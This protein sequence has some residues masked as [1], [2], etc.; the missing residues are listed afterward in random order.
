MALRSGISRLV[1][2][3]AGLMVVSVL[4]GE[5]YAIT[6]GQAV[7]LFAIGLLTFPI[8]GALIV[9]RQ[10]NAV[11][12]IMLGI[13]LGQGLSNLLSL[14][15][16]YSLRINPGSL[17]GPTFALAIDEASWVPLIGLVGTYLILLFP[18]GHLPSPRWKSWAWLCATT[19]VLIYL[20]ITVSPGPFSDQNY[21]GIRN[22][23]GIE[24][25]KPI[26][27]PL[28]AVIALLPICIVGCAV[29]MVRRFRRSRGQERLQLKWFTATTGLLAVSYL[30]LML[31]NLPFLLSNKPTPHWINVVG[32]IGIFPFILLPI[33]VGIAILKHRLYDI[34]VVINK[35]VV[36]G[37]L[38]AFITAVYV[39]I[40]V[41]IG[42][43]IG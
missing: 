18:D 14:Y 29:A 28:Y 34:D 23:L 35:T 2:V 17:P 41:G 25:L 39:A 10:P 5:I 19:M 11:G 4:G 30:I 13:G 16:E 12:W 31:L 15:A 43:L 3:A 27:G 38:G 9:S 26:I 40:V 1:W 22:P 6:Q 36:F 8:V 21:P 7:D 42:A 24:A 32:D 20:V 37:T 33:A